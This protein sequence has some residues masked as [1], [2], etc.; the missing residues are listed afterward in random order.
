MNEIE[1]ENVYHNFNKNK[2]MMN[3]LGNLP[4]PLP[5][6]KTHLDAVRRLI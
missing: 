6:D 2:E 3:S 1:A 4:P 5:L